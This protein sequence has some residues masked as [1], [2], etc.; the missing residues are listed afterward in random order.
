M[1][2]KQQKVEG[3]LAELGVEELYDFLGASPQ[4]TQKEVYWYV[5]VT[6]RR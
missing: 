4:S 3:I 1:A 2:G 5:P 6:A